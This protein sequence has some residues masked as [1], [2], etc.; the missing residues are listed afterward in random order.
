VARLTFERP[1]GWR[2]TY[3]RILQWGGAAV[4]A[5]AIAAVL[6]PWHEVRDSDFGGA[7]GCAFMPDCH[8]TPTPREVRMASPPDAVHSGLQHGGILLIGLLA[9]LI[10]ARAASLRWPRPWLAALVGAHTLAIVIVAAMATLLMHM[11]DHV[12]ERAGW[13]LFLP[14]VLTLMLVGLVDLASIAVVHLRRR[15]TDPVQVPPP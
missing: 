4:A 2:L 7:L 10:A 15:G 9:L 6:L 12:I 8:I 5:L 1:T 3:H 13:Y 14:A 11:F